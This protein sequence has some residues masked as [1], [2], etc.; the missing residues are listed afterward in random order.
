MLPINDLPKTNY[1]LIIFIAS[2]LHPP[3]LFVMVCYAVRI[4]SPASKQVGGAANPG[5]SAIQNM[6]TNHGRFHIAVAEQFLN[7]AAVGALLQQVRGE[8]MREG[9]HIAG[10]L[11]P[12]ACT[13]ARTARCKRLGSRWCLPSLF[14][15]GCHQRRL[16]GNSHSLPHSRAA[17][18]YFFSRARDSST[19]SQPSAR[20][21][22]C[23]PLTPCSAVSAAPPGWKA[24][25]CPGPCLPCRHAR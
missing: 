15:R 8:R 6:G 13:A 2:P 11:I 14:C 10:L 18:R 7:R 25:R 22:W 5:W 3:P 17:F 9:W 19:A 23:T 24:A 16:W 12:A 4:T 20:S 1:I 21:T